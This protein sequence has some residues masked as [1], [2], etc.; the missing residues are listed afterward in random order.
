MRSSRRGKAEAPD[1]QAPRWPILVGLAVAIGA[2]VAAF[3]FASRSSG[4][5]VAWTR[6]GTQDVHSLA[7]VDGDP[8]R[9]LFGHHGGLYAS[10]DGGRTW[11]SMPVRDDAMS[12]SPASDG[13]IV[14]AGHNV[15]AS[16]LDG[17]TTWSPISADLPNLD[18]HGFTRDPADP[19]RMWAYLATGGLWESR[20]FG[21][22]WE[23]LRDDN[24]L[25]PLAVRSGSVTRLLGVNTS[26]LVVSDDG[27]RSWSLL[28]MPETFPM[29]ALTA[30]PDGEVVYA[31]SPDGLFRSIDGG[32]TWTST[33]YRGSTFAVATTAD[34]GTVAVVSR[35]TEFFRSADGGASWPGP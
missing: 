33:T 16:S 21:R 1:R 15:F 30:T 17:G 6:F 5:P 4:E 25:F 20:D 31:G 27:G 14:I 19:A 24:V 13:S 32:R 12:T 9:L 2:T 18:I 11:T 35:E 34:G 26:G 29:T 7:F 10:A 8:S 22:T 28:S 23:R 3:L